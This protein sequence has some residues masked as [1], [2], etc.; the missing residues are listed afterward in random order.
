MKSIKPFEKRLDNLAVGDKEPI[1]DEYR[2]FRAKF[3][4]EEFAM[5]GNLLVTHRTRGLT[6][7]ESETL[8]EILERVDSRPPVSLPPI[9]PNEPRCNCCGEQPAYER[10]GSLPICDECFREMIGK[11]DD[12][13]EG[14]LPHVY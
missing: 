4:R 14:V 2:A 8:A 12:S 6:Q 13:F 11:A 1:N 3:T 7:A 10:D 9:N 5:V